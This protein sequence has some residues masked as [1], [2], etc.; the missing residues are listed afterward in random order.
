MLFLASAFVLTP[1]AL[2]QD[3]EETDLDSDSKT[4]KKKS[5]SSSR[6]DD[7]A[8]V[9]EIVRGFYGKASV[10]GVGYL[11]DFARV[12]SLSGSPYASW[13]T[14]VGFAVGQDFV[15][16]EKQSMA[17]EVAFHQGVNNGT[18]LISSGGVGQ[19]DEGCGAAPCTEGD[20]RTFT[21]QATYEFSF[22]PA[23]RIGVGFRAGG[24]AL[25]SP[26][27]I[28]SARWEEIV[29]DIGGDPGYHNSIHPYGVA[30][31]TF[32]YYTKLSHFSVGADVDVFY[33]VGW[34]LGANAVGTLKYTF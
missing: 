5:S 21:I 22:Y 30:G 2:A 24:G 27:L 8:K 29:A 3:E 6:E 32:E 14:S 17:W 7:A 9:R 34:D 15:D 1:S 26:L 20:L 11:L 31:P 10:G 23:R 18:E 25:Y 16:N 28:D 19:I 13:G 33:A 12:S 4:K